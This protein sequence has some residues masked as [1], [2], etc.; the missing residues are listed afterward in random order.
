M[1]P[2][3][4]GLGPSSE[5]T[6]RHDWLTPERLAHVRAVLLGLTFFFGLV[7]WVFHTL[8]PA[9]VRAPNFI[10]KLRGVG[11]LTWLYALIQMVDMRFYNSRFA[12]RRRAQLRIPE[13][14]NGWLLGQMV[15]WFG[16]LYYGLTEDLRWFIAGLV[17]FA[18]SFWAFPVREDKKTS[19][20]AS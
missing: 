11:V 16:I 7:V 5:V 1:V 15:A 8:G 9:T 12:K 20:S 14:L 6:N 17:I 13:S 3:I 19:S 10:F 2:P 18:L 4:A